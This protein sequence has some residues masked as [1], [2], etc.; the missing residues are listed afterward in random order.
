MT[1]L[2]ITQSTAREYTTST[3][4]KDVNASQKTK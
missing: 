4:S 1:N 3:N 2:K